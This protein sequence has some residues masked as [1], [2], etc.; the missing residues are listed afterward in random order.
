MF[1]R[2]VLKKRKR[3]LVCVT[4]ILW[5]ISSASKYTCICSGTGELELTMSESLFIECAGKDESK[6]CMRWVWLLVHVNF[7]CD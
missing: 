2:V 3:C 5:Y 1:E 6:V 7:A 4:E